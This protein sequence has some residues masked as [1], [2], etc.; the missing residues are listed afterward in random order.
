M[1]DK[2]GTRL[3]KLKL[4]ARDAKTYQSIE[5]EIE[6]SNVYVWS[7]G[8]RSALFHGVKEFLLS[9]Q[10]RSFRFFNPQR[11]IAWG[12]SIILI[13]SLLSALFQATQKKEGVPL[14]WYFCAYGVLLLLAFISY[15]YRR[16]DFGLNLTRRHDTFWLRNQDK[17]IVSAISSVVSGLVGFVLGKYLQ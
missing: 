5:V 2:C 7:S 1:V 4:H 12:A 10:L 13:I 16:F 15:F 11:W 17:V 6:G 9:K 3:N 14:H 8:S